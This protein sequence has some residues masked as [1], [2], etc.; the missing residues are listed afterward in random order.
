M[1][2]VN[3]IIEAIHNLPK[4]EREKI[5]EILAEEE[6]LQVDKDK[7][8]QE[9]I[10]RY[11]KARN[12][13]NEHSEEYMNQWVCLDGDK[14]IAFGTDGVEVHRKAKEAGI[15]TPFLHHIVDE[16]LPFGGW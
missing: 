3:E 7:E 13:I 12:W 8:V 14:L 16:S 4:G 1:Q 11:K 5:R 15:E 9:Q 10:A 2:S 6:K